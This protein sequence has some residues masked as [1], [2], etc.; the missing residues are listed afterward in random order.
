V[1]VPPGKNMRV[2]EHAR[3]FQEM[4]R[5]SLR[6][7]AVMQRLVYQVSVTLCGPKNIGS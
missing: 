1:V 5:D 2:C 6:S 4:Y 7:H 3:E